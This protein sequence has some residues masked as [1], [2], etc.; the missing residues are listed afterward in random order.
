M[1]KSRI[2][3]FLNCG[4]TTVARGL[5]NSHYK[6]W[7]KNV[8]E[9]PP[10]PKRKCKVAGC[11]NIHDSHGYCGKHSMRFKKYGT[12][13]DPKPRIRPVCKFPSCDNPN[14]GHGWCVK[15]YK[16]WKKFGDPSVCSRQM[17]EHGAPMKFFVEVVLPFEGDECLSWP[18]GRVSG[19]GQLYYNGKSRTVHTLA[20]EAIHGPSPSRKH[21]VAHSCGQGQHGCVNPRHLRWA[22]QVSNLA[23]RVTHGTIIRGEKTHTSKL[24]EE[25]I[26]NIRALRGSLTQKELALRFGVC[27]SNISAVLLGL[28]WSWL[29]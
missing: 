23:D 27:R 1:A 16:R 28:T 13:Q 2:C 17:P 6:Q 20:C 18:F 10:R 11:E 3:S 24:K 12:V 26:R 19:Y 15:H 14:Y 22:T 9:I 21:L 8:A 29:K 7:R 4:N 25:D 5:C